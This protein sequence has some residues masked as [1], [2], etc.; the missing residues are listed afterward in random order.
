ML[1]LWMKGINTSVLVQMSAVSQTDYTTLRGRLWP[2]ATVKLLRQWQSPP[3]AAI[4]AAC[5][6]GD[7]HRLPFCCPKAL[8]PLES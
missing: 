8:D 5:R 7:N 1:T 6:G 3:G 2:L 4:R